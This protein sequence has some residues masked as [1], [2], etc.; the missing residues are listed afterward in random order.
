MEQ[1]YLMALQILYM[2][3]HIFL[4]YL[5]IRLSKHVCKCVLVYDINYFAYSKKHCK[6]L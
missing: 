4:I 6:L 3:F 5:D 2:L 1:K